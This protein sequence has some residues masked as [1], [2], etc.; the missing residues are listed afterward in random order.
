MFPLTLPRLILSANPE[1]FISNFGQTL[2]NQTPVLFKLGKNL[3]QKV[4]PTFKLYN[5][6]LI[7]LL[8]GTL[9]LFVPRHPQSRAGDMEMQGIRLS[10]ICYKHSKNF[11]C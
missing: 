10:E 9:V 7:R 2:L 3:K 1:V 8:A 11:I 5:H 6:F 4:L